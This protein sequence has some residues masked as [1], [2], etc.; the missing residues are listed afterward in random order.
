MPWHCTALS[1][2]RRDDTPPNATQDSQ[3]LCEVWA[4][5]TAKNVT[6]HE[7]H[8]RK[9]G[10]PEAAVIK[11]PIYAI[12]AKE[13]ATVKGWD[14][15][16]TVGENNINSVRPMP[17]AGHSV[18]VADRWE[19]EREQESKRARE[20]E[21]EDAWHEKGCGGRGRVDGA[22]VPWTRPLESLVRAARS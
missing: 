8:L 21:R 10:A 18:H 19:R 6:P 3:D 9:Q 13:R 1:Q 4:F 14:T 12:S 16:S 20:Q 15:K 17:G 5:P 7:I 11:I 22:S 2:A